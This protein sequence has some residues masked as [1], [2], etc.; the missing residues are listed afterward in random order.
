MLF[1]DIPTAP[2]IRALVE[3]RADAC[4][5][6]YLPTTPETQKTDASRIALGNLARQ[7]LGQLE[8]AGLDKR[9]LAGIA[10]ALEALRADDDV[11]VTQA[12]TLAVL[13][14]PDR[15][16]TFRLAT[17]VPETVEV[18]DR[19]HLKPLLRALAFAQHAYVLALSENG[20]KLLEVTA[21]LPPAEVKVPNLPRDAAHAVGRASV[22]NLTQNTRIANAEGQNL[23]LRTYARKVD[24]ALRPLLAGR[25]TPLILAA[26]DPLASMFRA[27]C[28]YPALLDGVISGSPDRTSDAEFAAAARPLLDAHYSGQVAAVKAQLEQRAGEGRATS[29][30]AQAARAASWGAVDTLLVDIAAVLP[31]TIDGDGGLTLADAASA[32]SYDVLDEIAGRVLL[33]G[34]RVLAVRSEDLPDRVLL[35]A[36]LRY[37]V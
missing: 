4:V 28:S 8:A 6:L 5:S 2:E 26:A 13:A 33:S 30:V 35:A 17:A 11:W 23:L 1:V 21:D 16:Q 37:P 22:N 18:S 27:A 15:V 12:R 7:A 10:E 34:G 14:T 9:R 20:V 25:E 24:A 31:G 19:F 3:A 29:D 32:E 36:V